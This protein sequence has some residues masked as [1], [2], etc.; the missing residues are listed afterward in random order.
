MLRRL[1][2]DLGHDIP[3][4]YFTIVDIVYERYHH[5]DGV[6]TINRK[7]LLKADDD[8]QRGRGQAGLLCHAEPDGGL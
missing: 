7:G 8:K 2:G 4:L 5:Q 6:R 1:L 3:S